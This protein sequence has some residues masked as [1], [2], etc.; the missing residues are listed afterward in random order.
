MIIV[1]KNKKMN[2][3]DYSSFGNEMIDG[4]MTEESD[5]KVYLLRDAIMYS[6]ILGR[7]LTDE[8]MKKFEV[9]KF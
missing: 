6:K 1:E 3:V 7:E 4:R 5:G 2:D 8:E 9:K